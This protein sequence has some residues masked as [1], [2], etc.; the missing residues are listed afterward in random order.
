MMLGWYHAYPHTDVL[1]Y[2][3][4]LPVCLAMFSIVYLVNSIIWLTI[5][6]YIWLHHAYFPIFA[7][8]SS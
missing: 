3:L 5:L 8:I 7:I 2:S 1:T 6:Q 4:C